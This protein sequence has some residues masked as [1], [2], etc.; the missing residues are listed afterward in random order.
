VIP[1]RD[2]S[3]CYLPKGEIDKKNLPKNW[4]YPFYVQTSERLF[5]LCAKNSDERNMWMAGFRYVIASTM[6]V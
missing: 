4:A 6:T 2:I 5:V 1:F 3:D